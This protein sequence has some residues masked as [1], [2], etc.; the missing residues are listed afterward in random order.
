MDAQLQKLLKD[1]EP[2]FSVEADGR[3]KCTLNGHC[4]PARFDV[5]SA[6]VKYVGTT[7][8]DFDA[9]KSASNYV[10]DAKLSYSSR[11]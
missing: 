8:R 7:R 2:H 1:E 3:I 11:R 6:F 10:M 9:I 4:F 5:I